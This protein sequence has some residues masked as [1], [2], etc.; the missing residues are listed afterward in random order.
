M[1]KVRRITIIKRKGKFLRENDTFSVSMVYWY[2]DINI[3][4]FTRSCLLYVKQF[5]FLFC[6]EQ[7]EVLY[8]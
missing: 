7:I 8:R 5:L 3:N 2:L 6:V 1:Q 4:K